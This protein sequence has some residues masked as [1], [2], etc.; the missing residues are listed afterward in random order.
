MSTTE[1]TP[2]WPG[3]ETAR[4]IGR[5]SF[6]AVYEI[7]RSVFGE[8]ERCALKYISIPQDDSEIRDM[9][10]EGMDDKSITRSFEEQARDIVKEY[11]L[12]MQLND[13]PN[14]VHCYDV[15]SVQKDEGFGWDIY[16]RMELLTPLTE[17]L[18]ETRDFAE[19]DT[20]KLAR[21]IG[22]ALRDC[23]RLNIVHRD[24][25]PQNIFVSKDGRYKLGDFGIA[26]ISEM[27]GSAT[28]R[29]GTYSTMAPEVFNGEPYGAAADVYSLG[30][31]LYWLLNERRGPFVSVNTAAEKNQALRRRMS[32]EA[33]PAPVNG[34]AELKGIVLKC[35]AFDPKERY[36]SAEELLR[37]LENAELEY[38]EPTAYVGAIHESPADPGE[39]RFAPVGVGVL[40]DPQTSRPPVTSNAETADCT[41]GAGLGPGRGQ[42]ERRFAPVGV[43]APDDPK[44]ATEENGLSRAPAPTAE[45]AEK[46]VSNLER[47]KAAPETGTRKTNKKKLILPAC[48]A[49]AA[50]AVLLA[51]LLLPGNGKKAGS[52]TAPLVHTTPK[53]VT[54]TLAPATPEPETPA[55][56]VDENAAAYAE[57]EALA[58]RGKTYEAAL[59]FYA[60][61]DYSDAWDRCFALWGQITQRETV[62]AGGMHTVALRTDGTVLAVG[63]NSS[64]QCDVDDWQG[65][66]AV[67]A[68]YDHT[69]GLRA[70]GTVVA[71]GANASGQCDVGEWQD[72]VAVSAGWSHTVGLRADGT[73]VAAGR[74]GFGQCSVSHWQDVV[75][76]SAGEDCT[77]GLRSDGTVISTGRDEYGRRAVEDWQNIVAISAGEYHTVG[78]R[79]DGTVVAVGRN[80]NGECDVD[81]WRDIVAISAAGCHT[82]GL[83]SDGTVLELGST[84]LNA[85][86]RIE[87][88]NW[89]D[90][91]AASAGQ[92]WTVGL[93]ADGTVLAE[94]IGSRGQCNVGGWT[95]IALPEK[96]A[97]N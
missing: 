90:I 81:G 73:V 36:R 86:N 40:D 64:G 47:R 39:R 85:N 67:S 17:L 6:G 25:K 34:S 21:D 54:E 32:G 9:K 56:V 80:S 49:V 93:R 88:E 46:T 78:L 50:I 77:F 33:L 22:T 13:C 92:S 60:I 62:S 91:V 12:M 71:V 3:W 58:A 95:D 35:C 55:P 43:G 74:D 79:A 45:D 19:A 29:V 41:L 2:V 11:R 4:L 20:V 89:K 24:V 63:Y 59:A 44:T 30:M 14:V 94:G 28:A 87:V 48:C 57:A 51:F 16:I 72:I 52:S 27:T 10:S 70:D 66:V 83:R 8:T 82:A 75:A 53:P 42:G 61:K 96:R 65:I 7:R 23:R 18:S 26:R 1:K 68:G 76:I 84:S 69:A 37:D 5:G 31:V 97:R 38:E 15:E